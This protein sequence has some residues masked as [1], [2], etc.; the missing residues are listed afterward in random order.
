MLQKLAMLQKLTF[1]GRAVT[2]QDDGVKC[3]C[4]YEAVGYCRKVTD[5]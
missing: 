4:D 2:V 5:H 3:Y 1:F